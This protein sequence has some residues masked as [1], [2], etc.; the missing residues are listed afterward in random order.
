[1]DHLKGIRLFVSVVES[2]SFIGAAKAENVAQSTVSKEVSALETRLGTQLLR[3]SSRGLSVTDAGQE[4][5]NFAIG[6]LAD[7]NS[8]ESRLR[9]GNISLHGRLR[10]ALPLV[11]SSRLI[12]PALPRLLERFPNLNLDI[13]AS[14]RYANL[15]EEG[16]DIAVRIGRRLS[17]SNLRAWQIGCLEPVVVASPAY[18]KNNGTPSIPADLA[19]HNCLPFLFQRN[20]KSWKFRSGDVDVAIVPNGRIRT[21]DADSVHAAVRAGMGLAQGPSWMFAEDINNGTLVT[22]LDAYT[23]ELVPIWAVTPNR[24]RMDGA[25]KIFVDEVA[26]VIEEDPYLRLRRRNR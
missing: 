5:F 17:D 6:M 2:G 12:T 9:T 7:L 26:S 19:H 10:V 14:E 15:V 16:F 22:V 24:H 25:I 11:F 13:E 20:S 21:N 1:M 3:R 4:Y 23:A 8:V 18:L